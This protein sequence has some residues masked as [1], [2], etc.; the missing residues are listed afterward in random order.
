MDSVFRVESSN[1]TENFI[2]E[3]WGSVK[4][5]DVTSWVNKLLTGEDVC[6]FDKYNLTRSGKF[7]KNSITHELWD[8]IRTSVPDSQPSGPQVF[9]AIVLSH[10]VS[11]ATVVRTLVMELSNLRLNKIPGENV[12][13]L[14][15]LV[16]EKAQCI[17]G[18]GQEPRDFNML[19][20][21]CFLQSKSSQFEAIANKIHSE[22][23]D[24]KIKDWKT[25]IV[26]PLLKKYTSL[27]AQ[28]LW[29]TVGNHTEIQGLHA[30][31]IAL[32]ARLNDGGSG[33]SYTQNNDSRGAGAKREPTCWKCG[34]KGHV[35]PN[36]PK[37]DENGSSRTSAGNNN[38]KAPPKDGENH[39]RTRD[40]VVEKWCRRCRRWTRG[41]KAHL[42]EEHISKKDLTQ[43][44]TAN[45][46]V[47]E[48]GDRSYEGESY[49]MRT[50][51]YKAVFGQDTPDESSWCDL[52]EGFKPVSHVCEEC[53]PKGRAGQF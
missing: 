4:E 38:V 34:E 45:V 39:T 28:G 22:A 12:E 26:H 40:G 6:K 50:R 51:L 14:S 36:C 7:L 42:T 49:L 32:E 8:R 18:T 44:T 11:S 2:L 46:G 23:D 48:E 19:V 37:S 15:Q 17:C 52:C 16:I 10:Q 27:K 29:P 33:S 30:K 21:T 31:I 43:N 20:A 5:E 35:K 47:S 53:H 1:G 9:T 13:L 24:M 41:D 25:E 3:N